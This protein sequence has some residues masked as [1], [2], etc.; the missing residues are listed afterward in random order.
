MKILFTGGGT[1]GHIAPCLAVA[2]Q[3]I[4]R[5]EAE[6]LFVGRRGGREN[7]SI[8][9][10]NHPFREIDIKSL[11]SCS[12]QQKIF[13]P[14]LLRKARKEAKEILCDFEPDAV[15]ASGGYV[16]YPIVREAAAR[17]IP[18]YIHESNAVAGRATKL[19]SKYAKCLFLGMQGSERGFRFAERT[20]FTSTPVRKDFFQWTRASARKALGIGEEFMILS[21]GGSLGAQRLNDTMLEFM[22]Q[23]SMKNDI[24]H[25]H[26]CGERYYNSLDEKYDFFKDSKGNCRAVSYLENV[27]PYMKA[28]DIV[29][30]RAGASSISEIRACGACSVLIPSP[31]VK[32]DHQYHN[33]CTLIENGGAIL[34]RERDLNAQSLIDLV[35]L[36]KSS[37]SKRKLIENN[38]RL[39]LVKDSARMITQTIVSDLLQMRS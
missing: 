26:S 17:F 39:P 2:E 28:A 33:A 21:L 14:S 16:C 8:I 37:P 18:I 9:A 29:I 38:A 22:E 36:L 24:V 25:I 32:N 20:I 6:V 12:F 7:H 4:K 34:L 15:F 1:Q 35:E 11:E 3:F 23:Y 19:L 27:A 10:R 13:Y 31:N 5:K 30:S